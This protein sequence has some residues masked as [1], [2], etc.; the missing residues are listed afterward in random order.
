MG[1]KTARKGRGFLLSSALVVFC[2]GSL[3][4]TTAAAQS[5]G[6]LVWTHASGQE[7]WIG[8]TV[9][10]GNHGENVFAE[11]EGFH[12]Y[13]RIFSAQ[14]ANPPTPLW[15]N[16]VS[17]MSY[18]SK[19]DAAESADVQVALRFD[20]ATAGASRVPVVA[21]YAS[22][23]STPQWTYSFPF[24]VNNTGSGIQ[25]SRDGQT[26]VAWVYD[27][28]TL[29]TA[30]AVFSPSSGTPRS[31]TLLYTAGVP[32]TA[33]LSA[34]GSTLLVVAAIKTIVFAVP[35]AS[36]SFELFNS[37][38]LNLGH[39]ISGNGSIFALTSTLRQVTLHKRQGST[40]QPWFTHELDANAAC[41]SVALSD[42]GSTMVCGF[43][44]GSPYL[45]VRTQVVDLTSALHPV[46][47]DE[48]ITGGGTQTNVI[49]DVDISAD[50]SAV[51][52][53]LSGDQQGLA[54]EVVMYARNAQSSAWSRIFSYNLPGSVN[55]I[56]IS[57]DGRRIATAS[58]AVHMS[59]AG[60]GGRID[61][62]RAEATAPPAAD[63]AVFGTAHLGST[64]T[65]RQYLAPGTP[66]MLLRASA[67][68]AIPQSW[69]DVGTLYLERPKTKTVA[70]GVAASNGVFET[71]MTVPQDA[72]LVGRTF[73]FQGYT[74][75]PAHLTHDWVSVTVLP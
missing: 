5:A 24:T 33:E 54:P 16:A 3:L 17:Y 28:S 11:F 49:T 44:Y 14:D 13:T 8:R 57:A 61:L 37:Q 38:T 63:I 60:S 65:F 68:A 59:M 34:D 27:Y 69:P 29:K 46:V 72:T 18:A 22:N 52:V 62:F 25:I 55:D 35:S 30:V 67:L 71:S 20:Q 53:G 66:A 2:A 32:M 64:I 56:D 40:Y 47:L 75:S 58:K 4:A 48:S 12:G 15:Q 9:A 39:A 41:S 45:Q 51:A 70:S 7:N 1:I 74:T 26:I 10:L 31:Y 21:R 19:V 42:N 36:V 43:N 50:G 23:S 6:N 73:Y